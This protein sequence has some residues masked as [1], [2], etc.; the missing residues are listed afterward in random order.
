[1]NKYNK[2]DLKN[3]TADDFYPLT[4]IMASNLSAIYKLFGW[5]MNMKWLKR[6]YEPRETLDGLI[7]SCLDSLRKGQKE[8]SCAT[9]GMK[10]EMWIEEEEIYLEVFYCVGEW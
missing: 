5:D 3:L 7:N 4:D 9:G 8:T 2:K 10:I 1:M 6:D